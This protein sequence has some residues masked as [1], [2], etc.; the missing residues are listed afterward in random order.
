MTADKLG[1]AVYHHIG[2]VLKRTNEDGSKGIVHNEEDAMAMGYLCNGIQV[3]NI[4][5]GIAKSLGIDNLG[6]GANGC[7]QGL[8]VIDVDDGVV[9]SLCGERMG[10]EVEGTTIEI[11]GSH[12][13][14]T[15]LKHILQSISHCCCST[16]NCQAS[17][18]TLEGCHTA[19]KYILGAV[20]QTAIDVTCIAQSE[21]VGSML[22]IAEYITGGLIN[23]HC[24]GIACGVGGLLTYM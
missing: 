18:T 22:G 10:D 23:G 16:G 14:V 20:G 7:L 24:A 4:A 13:M 12:N 21:T 9:H 5:I 2:T 8:Q 3:G 17:H 19:L 6:I 1:G 15:V 11:V